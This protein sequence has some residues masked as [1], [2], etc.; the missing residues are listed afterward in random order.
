MKNKK[1]YIYAS[2]AATVILMSILFGTILK[3]TRAN[4]NIKDGFSEFGSSIT[5]NETFKDSK[6]PL[7]AEIKYKDFHIYG[8]NKNDDN[9]KG[10]VVKYGKN[11]KEYDVT[12]MT[13]MFILPKLKV[14][15]LNKKE[16]IFSSFNV[17]SGS[18]VYIEDLYGFYLNSD[19]NLEEIYFSPKEYKSQL[20]K[21]IK[22]NI[23]D[24]NMLNV[25]IDGCN[26][27][28]INLKRLVEPTWKL[29]KITYGN[30]VSFIFDDGINIRL[31][32]EAYFENIVTPQYIGTIEAKI[33][34]NNDNL[35]VLKD[36]V[37]TDN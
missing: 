6:Y 8:I 12:Y 14:M 26:N 20:D 28:N 10:I 34:I 36:I 27:F 32:L 17:A 9:Y 15:E 1:V 13:P 18:E 37:I 29:N 11:T 30:N 23:K 2:I 16:V 3:K 4:E 35:F 33:T 7:L 5:N 22:Y 19:G 24:N 25:I 21:A 31:G